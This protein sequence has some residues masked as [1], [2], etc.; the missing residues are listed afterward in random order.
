MDR[1][2]M[3]RFFSS[4]RKYLKM[5][6]SRLSILLAIVSVTL[7]VNQFAHARQQDQ[8]SVGVFQFVAATIDVVGLEGEVSYIVRNELRKKP[9]Y[10]VINQRELEKALTRNDIIQKFSADEAVKA[11]TVLNLNYVIV[12]QVRREN[13]QIVA[14]IEVVSPIQAKAIGELSF[15][16]TNQAQIALQSDYIGEQI[17]NIITEHKIE[18]ERVVDTLDADWIDTLTAV[19]N[20]GS[21]VLSW[22]LTNPSQ[23][24]LGFNLYR[25]ES[26]EGPFSYLSSESELS[27]TDIPG[28]DAAT[29]YYR[30]S[31]IDGNGE[32]IRSDTLATV[33][34]QETVLSAIEPPTIMQ[35][36]ERVSSVAVEFFP[37]AANV[38]RSIAGY[39]LLRRTPTTD[40]QVVGNYVLPNNVSNSRQQQTSLN[41]LTIEDAQ[42]SSIN[43]T[44]IYGL[45]AFSLSEKGQVTEPFNYSPAQ[46]PVLSLM[47]NDTLREIQLGWQPASAGFGYR[48]YRKDPASED[49][50]LLTELP[51]VSTASFTDTDIQEEGQ[52]FE[53]AISVYDDYGETP[54]S[55]VLTAQSKGALS[56]PT[57]VK[58]E[59]GL[60][61]AVKISWSPVV[62][63]DVKGYSVFRGPFTEDQEFTL[64]RI[65]EVMDPLATSFIDEAGLDDGMQ[66]YYSV[67]SINQFNVSGPVSKAVLVS[68][69]LPPEP[70]ENLNARFVDETVTL[71]WQLPASVTQ[72]DVANFVL[73]RSF[74]GQNFNVVQE[75]LAAQQ[76]YVDGD[77]IA[78]AE[79][80]YRIKIVDVDGLN[81]AYTE[82][83]P[84]Q[85]LLP[86][87]LTNPK[88]G[89]LRQISLAWE[90][91]ALPATIKVFRGEDESSL[92]FVSEI[93]DYSENSY[94]DNQNLED[95][96]SY[97][98]KIES[99]LNGN[100]LAESNV[101]NVQTKD[102][103][104][105]QNLI[106]NSNLPNRIE[107]TWN[108]VDDD[109]IKG[110]VIFRR[111]K[112][113][114]SKQLLSIALL[115]DANQTS[116]VDNVTEGPIQSNI[117]GVT[118]IKHGVE[119]EYAIASK[120]IFD[121]TGF[122]GERVTASSKPLPKSVSDVTTVA[123][124]NQI[125]ISW[126]VGN[127]NDLKQ[128][129]IERKWP[130]EN[131]FTEVTK[132]AANDNA[133][134]DTNIYPYVS[135]TYQFRVV[136]NDELI[137]APTIVESV[138]NIKQVELAVQQ[139]KLLRQIII[140]WESSHSNV[141]AVVNRRPVGSSEWQPLATLSSSITSYIDKQG[142]LDQ[143]EY[144]Y[145][146]TL[147]TDDMQS[148]TLGTSNIVQAATKDLPEAP[149]LTAESG[150]VKS[151][152]L[153]WTPL[154]DTDVAGYTVYKVNDDGELD[155]LETLKADQSSY[156]D[157]GSFFSR[158]EDGASYSYQIASF[159][160]FE[161]EGTKGE[162]VS[163]S[164]KPLPSIPLGVDAQVA[165]TGV[166]INWTANPE[167][168]IAKY[169]IYRGSSCSRVSQIGSTSSGA[170]F[171]FTDN[172]A[173]AG[174]TYCYKVKAIDS[175]E[176]ESALSLGS[177]VSL[178]EEATQ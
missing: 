98:V 162:L 169:E 83:P 151:V 25:A 112:N 133:F 37:S 140:E 29:Y 73:E 120:N 146:L 121:A 20:S 78:G 105:P 17:H 139:D 88:P 157:T 39:E 129:I 128:V 49:F 1:I 80:T 59:S 147:Q 54:K 134:S 106:V 94:I 100:L 173:R 61:R 142:L 44:V 126:Q 22:T 95:D 21:V 45:R 91:A 170:S 116:F 63:P 47:S 117:V 165:S 52:L 160:T 70:I 38:T 177:T 55:D 46:P 65:G 67:A 87:V 113:G 77:M 93:T 33:S 161:V 149:V 27:A 13:Q 19:N 42:A 178:P 97:S 166:A 131:D 141:G 40:W 155:K 123:K 86:L 23:E 50:T 115:D 7:A 3:S 28:S 85:I 143:K 51:S 109:S 2:L 56:P 43:G 12:G 57:E 164:T 144:D 153:D 118:S 103:P 41:K 74:D 132:V 9:G 174:R 71:S 30:V 15:T 107:L 6:K 5:T 84:T 89:M 122:V 137:S 101:I 152:K 8:S 35:V 68:T 158:L 92:A 60:V 104:A 102:I 145:Q 4:L 114:A 82:S 32:E 150:L 31:M 135:P 62:D 36:I 171:T 53:Y 72:D 138:S 16:F 111:E 75:F 172:K 66:Y 159:N 10:M 136:D 176:L 168:D 64:T 163:A 108:K 125:D 18:S 167:S 110:Y 79:A 26:E 175:T 11:A 148:F 48:V 99:W 69:K 156:T 130:F 127:E 119:Y 24:F 14:N 34:V 58:G 76:S 81:S 96:K 124:A 90:N 154:T